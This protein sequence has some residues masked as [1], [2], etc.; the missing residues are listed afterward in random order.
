MTEQVQGIDVK[1]LPYT[2]IGNGTEIAGDYAELDLKGDWYLCL[3]LVVN[4]TV[5]R[6][7]L[8]YHYAIFSPHFG[9][10]KYLGF[11]IR[12]LFGVEDFGISELPLKGEDRLIRV[13]EMIEDKFKSDKELVSEI[14]ATKSKP[15][16][17]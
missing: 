13:A 4:T 2:A 14:L 1:N 16:Q 12:E 5:R 10:M 9:D 17:I 7:A 15:I 8:R 3:G 11:D 6:K